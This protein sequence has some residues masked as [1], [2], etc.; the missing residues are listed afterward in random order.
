[1]KKIT[2]FVEEKIAPPLIKF[3]QLKYI[4][5]MQRVGLGVMP[6]LVIGSLFLLVVAFPLKEWKDF[7]GS[8]RTVI[9]S[10]AG[11]GTS[12]IALYTLLSTSYGLIEYYRSEKNEK[13]DPV[14]PMILS[15]AAFLMLNPI[16]TVTTITEGVEGKFSGIPSRY[17]G[18]LGVFV[19]IIVGIV[20][21]EIYRFFA[22]RKVTIKMPDGVPPMVSQSFASLVPGFFVILFFWFIGSVLKL[23]I[24]QMISSVFTPLVKV[25]D[26]PLVVV[27]ST[28]LNRLLWSVGIHGSNIVN[29]VGGAFWTQMSQLNLAAFEAGEALPHVFT[30]VFIDNYVWTGL[31]PLAVILIMSKSPRL[32]ALG[33]LSIVAALFN[34]G[35][36]LIFGLPI[37]LNPLLMIP[38]VL[39]YVTLSAASII[40]VS[41]KLIPVPALLIT[42]ITPAPIKTFLATAG[43]IPAT[44]FVLLGWVFIFVCFYPFVKVIEKKD[45]EEMN[46]PK[47]DSS[48]D[49]SLE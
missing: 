19:A 31:F 10:A 46:K 24:P 16:Q 14:Q 5:V 6:L 37:M 17:F 43:S 13:H 23:D 11:V 45:L 29:S 9:A 48:A 18:A 39:S 40:A 32:K 41:L 26:S 7:L 38:F 28:L 22:N 33:K 27:I 1:M 15:V 34:I 20:A 49:F 35:E 8:Y 2:Q 3:S 25:G 21:V 42:W 12:F 36:P 44:V 30:S 4:K 47:Q